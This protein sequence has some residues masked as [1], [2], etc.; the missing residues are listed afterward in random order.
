M[1]EVAARQFAEKGFSGTSMRSIA[2]DT[3]T[4]Q[5]AIYHHFP[6][7]DA[8]YQA[9]LARHFE[10]RATELV[11][12][13]AEIEDLRERLNGLVRTILIMTAEDEQFRQLYFRELLEGDKDRLKALA[14]NVFAGLVELATD[15]LKDLAPGMDTHLVLMS[16]AGLTIHHVEARKLTAHLPDA[17]P[18][19][20]QLDVIAGHITHL[21]EH[22]LR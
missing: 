21:L 9:V 3:G 22:G 7:K 16:I 11:E 6:N 20:Q 12:P 13:L 2:A 15:L 19:N 10:E 5:A 14:D 1:L 4:T 18:E 8:L 17:R